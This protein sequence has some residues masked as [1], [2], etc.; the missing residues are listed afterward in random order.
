MVLNSF[1]PGF[2][3]GTIIEFPFSLLL[4]VLVEA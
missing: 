4:P 1:I 3:E 2:T